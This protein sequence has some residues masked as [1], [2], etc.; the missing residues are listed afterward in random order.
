MVRSEP[1]S[2]Y[3][4]GISALIERLRQVPIFQS[5]CEE[6]TDLISRAELLH[7]S[8]GEKPI[9][10]G[11]PITELW[12]HLDGA[13]NLYL[14]TGN[15][16][17]LL[18]HSK[19]NELVGESPLF[20]GE[21]TRG[22]LEVVQD[23]T[24]LRI[25]L[26]DLGEMMRDCPEIRKAIMSSLAKRIQ[27]FQFT[28]MQ[29][30]KM[31]SIG[32]LAAGLMHELNNP[33]AA[34]QRSAAQLRQNLVRMQQISLR[35]CES[36]LSPEQ[37]ECLAALQQGLYVGT[38]AAALGTLEQSDREE[39]M[40]EWLEQHGV[41][42]AWKLA[43]PL[44]GQG[45]TIEDLDCA[46]HELHGKVFSDALNWL[47]ALGSSMGLLQTVEE[48]V[49]RITELVTA[50]KKYSSGSVG[51]RNMDVHDTLR[52]A[53]LILGYKLRSK[54]IHLEKRFAASLPP[55]HVATNGM[56]QVWTNLLDNAIDA[57][58]EGGKI[59]IET[60]AE[61]GAILVSIE[62]NGPGI[63]PELQKQIFDPFFTTK[64]VG[65]GTGL[66]LDIVQRKVAKCG[67]EILLE[68]RPGRTRFTVRIPVTEPNGPGPESAG[69]VSATTGQKTN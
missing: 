5:L 17:L 14:Q 6:E 62:D 32:T 69:K 8:V 16:R 59:L 47:E 40:A 53:L 4:G 19:G 2:N 21:P 43:P 37:L 50:V 42:N 15:D 39:K 28:V 49:S 3:P 20:T 48:S 27:S 61:P 67:G 9:V 45:L 12:V 11:M 23:S 57:V 36:P 66:G 63:P 25:P 60:E 18:S 26:E 46:Q 68:S 38:P 44:V 51:D 55:L 33:S 10:P 52:S 41:E 13:F 29:R 24:F 35:L 30:E 34:A 58:P 1:A 64:E 22:E 56:P 31:I 7:A 65:K 54:N